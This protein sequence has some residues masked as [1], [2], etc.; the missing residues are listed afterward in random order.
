MNKET[1]KIQGNLGCFGF[2]VQEL[3]GETFLQNMDIGKMFFADFAAEKTNSFW[4]NIPVEL[5]PAHINRASKI[6]ANVRTEE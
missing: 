1:Q 2:C 3:H 6:K 5:E 4:G